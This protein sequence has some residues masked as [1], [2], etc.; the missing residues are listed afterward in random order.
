MPEIRSALPDQARLQ[1]AGVALEE[2]SGRDLVQLAGWPDS[3]GPVGIRLAGLLDCPVPADTRCA[4]TGGEITVF[5]VGPER[6]WI[7]APASQGLG[8]RLAGAFASAEAVVTEL[9]H[10]RTVIGLGG[11]GAAALLARGVAVDLDPAVFPAGSFAHTRLHHTSVLLHRRGTE[12]FDLYVPRS[13]ALAVWD[14][15]AATIR[16]F[17]D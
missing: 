13:Y 8:G 4:V 17:R 14:W 5:K 9:G 15:F 6:L 1:G 11:A 12:A 7:A 16:G 2:V 3:F 10:S